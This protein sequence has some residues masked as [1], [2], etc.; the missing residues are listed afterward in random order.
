MARMMPIAFGRAP[1]VVKAKSPNAVPSSGGVKG[2]G[3]GETGKLL[4]QSEPF[5]YL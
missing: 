4:E 5:H 1:M 3:P 2:H